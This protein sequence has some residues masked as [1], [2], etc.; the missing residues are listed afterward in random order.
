MAKNECAV[1]QD[2][3]DEP[4]AKVLFFGGV[5]PLQS[6]RLPA[7]RAELER[8]VSGHDYR[9]G[10][11]FAGDGADAPEAEKDAILWLRDHDIDLTALPGMKR[12]AF[13]ETAA[14]LSPSAGIGVG[15]SE[16]LANRP[17]VVSINGVRLGFLSVSERRFA[18]GGDSAAEADILDLAAYDRVRMLLP[19]C[20]H[21]VVFCRAGL[22]GRACRCR[23]GGSDTGIL[24]RRAPAL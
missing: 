20:D 16:T 7:I 15:P 23:S 10:A 4:E 2:A 21:V 11:L 9:C 5:G 24:S 12:N 8:Y 14:A 19:Q 18:R 17:E 6:R 22:P 3:T 1:R 13:F